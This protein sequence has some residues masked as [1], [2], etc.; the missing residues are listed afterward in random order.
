[1]P[2]PGDYD[3]GEIGGMI[4]R[5]N[6]STREEN[7]STTNSTRSARTPTPGRHVG[8]T[9]IN[10]FNYG[11]ALA[12]QVTFIFAFAKSMIELIL[13]LIFPCMKVNSPFNDN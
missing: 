3:D 4:G 7:L 13:F 6:R 12:V 9:A 8:K 5:G 10:R 2:A 1:V 11:P